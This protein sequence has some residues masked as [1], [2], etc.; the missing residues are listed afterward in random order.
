VTDA[1]EELN[2]L[3]GCCICCEAGK[4]SRDKWKDTAVCFAAVDSQEE[5]IYFFDVL[6]KVVNVVDADGT[7]LQQFVTNGKTV[8]IYFC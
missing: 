1:C 6:E 2:T 3:S 5:D 8:F 7:N 4:F